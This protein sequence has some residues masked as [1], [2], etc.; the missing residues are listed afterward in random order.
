MRRKGRGTAIVTVHP[1]R[2]RQGL[3][4]RLVL[5]WQRL[6][7]GPVKS[8]ARARRPAGSVAQVRVRSMRGDEGLRL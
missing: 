5:G 2:R 6:A 7:V 4:A 8:H 3:I 1:W